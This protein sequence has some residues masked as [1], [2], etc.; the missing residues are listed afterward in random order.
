MASNVEVIRGLYESFGKGDVGAVLGLMDEKVDWQEPDSLPFEDQIGP[1]AV[2][3]NIFGQ[4]VQLV[5][6]FSVTTDEIHDAGDVVFG[7]GTYRGKG[8]KTG[9]EFEAA[10]VHV[11]RMKDG[12]IAGFRTYTDTHIWLQALGEV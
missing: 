1:Q 4:L 9:K 3:E 6:N 2:G 10:F 7:V 5:E 11:W 8:A 12:K